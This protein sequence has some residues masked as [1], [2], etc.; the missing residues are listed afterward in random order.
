ML[1]KLYLTMN[2]SWQL[3]NELNR[4]GLHIEVYRSEKATIEEIIDLAIIFNSYESRA[5]EFQKLFRK[6][7]I[8]KALLINFQSDKE[9][10]ATNLNKNKQFLDEIVE[11]KIVEIQNIDIFNYNENVQKIIDTIPPE[12]LFYGARWFIDITGEPSIYSL[13]LLKGIK[14]LFP[15]PLLYMLNVSGIYD[16]LADKTHTHFS[17]GI[18]E[19]IKIPFYEGIPDYSKPWKYIFLLGFEGERSLSILKLNEPASCEVIIAKPGYEKQY[20]DAPLNENECF[21][22]ELSYGEE[23]I[24]FTDIGDV[25]KLV[26]IFENIFSKIQGKMNICIVP[27][28]PKPHA[29]A[30]GIFGL[31]HTDISIMYQIPQ[32]YYLKESKRGK[33]IWLYKIE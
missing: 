26:D 11:D 4:P 27:L 20:E 30:A 14:Q 29:L 18:K 22:R 31:L 9:I 6:G 2:K 19:D 33:Y 21:L 7:Q 8:K 1:K 3:I 16:S 12:C 17:E 25:V 32:K 15:S 28:G 23:D 10:K 5:L 13:A 24:I